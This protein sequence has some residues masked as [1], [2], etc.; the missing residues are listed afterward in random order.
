MGQ[1]VQ[2]TFIFKGQSVFL[3][4]LIPKM[5]T[6]GFFEMSQT[7]VKLSSPISSYVYHR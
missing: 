3:C 5:K 7:A 1:W 6:L 4:I 2:K